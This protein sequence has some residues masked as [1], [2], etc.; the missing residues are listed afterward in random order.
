M[1][2]LIQDHKRLLDE[3]G[4][5]YQRNIYKELKSDHRITGIIG[6]RGVG[7][8]TYI[9]DYLKKNYADSSRALYISADDIYFSNNNLV[10]LAEKF[11]REYDGEILCIDEIHKY[12][13]WSRELKNIYDKYRKLKVIFSGSSSIDLVKEKYDLSRRAALRHLPGLSFRE[14]L[15]MKGKGEFPRM[16]LN[17]I[18][19]GKSSKEN[20]IAKTSDL[21]PLFK[22]YLKIGYYPFFKEYSNEKDMYESLEGV[23]DKIIHMDIASYYSLKTSTL[24][25]FKKILYFIH[26]SPPSSININRIAKSLGKDHSDTANYL[27]MM[28]ASG[29]LRFLLVDKKGHALL[30]NTEKI[31][32]NNTN[33]VK[34][35]ENTTGKDSEAGTVRELFVISSL[36]D[37]SLRPFYSKIGDLSCNGY[38]FEIGGEGKDFSRL[39]NKKNSYL[40]CDDI[41]YREPG[42]I[43]M[44]LFGFLY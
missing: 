27:E 1:E 10:D 26:T 12:P 6:A 41:L 43:P 24:N 30:R 20:A 18:V 22:Q 28:R 17:E 32:I 7:K 15:E 8:T 31:Y 42:K 36:E 13:G 44:Y 37:A 23:I 25:V 34:A 14:Y 39:K 33:L 2:N 3:L 4:E 38:T 21:F 11:V 9:L 5:V 40:I 35:L 16:S 29:L 19:K